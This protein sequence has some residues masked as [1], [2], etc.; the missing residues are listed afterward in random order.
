MNRLKAVKRQRG[1]VTIFV[2]MILLV[3]ITLLVLTAFSLSKMNLQAASNVQ[4]REEG[5]AA[6]NVVI[7]RTI[8]L[9]FWNNT[10][11]VNDTVDING[12]ADPDFQVVLAVPSCVRATEAPGNLSAS[13]TLQG[14]SSINAW[15][16]IWE[17]DTIATQVSTGTQVQVIQGVRVLLS[18]ALKEALCDP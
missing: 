7:D 15:F 12:D 5:L 14:M 10:A 8:G 11:A 2:S 9:E 17:L 16:T 4:A 18:T 13:I 1:V 6:A 3:L